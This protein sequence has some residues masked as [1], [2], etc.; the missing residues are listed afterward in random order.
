MTTNPMN[1]FGEELAPATKKF[2]LP[3]IEARFH[4]EV[5]REDAPAWLSKRF[6]SAQDVFEI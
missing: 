4:R 5:V 3:A 1:L 2:T 6:T